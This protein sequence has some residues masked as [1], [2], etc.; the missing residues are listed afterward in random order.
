MAFELQN[1][2]NGLLEYCARMNKKNQLKKYKD[3]VN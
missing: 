1:A 3:T 2:S